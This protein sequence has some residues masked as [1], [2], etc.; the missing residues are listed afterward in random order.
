MAYP[1]GT[2]TLS[3]WGT[4][5]CTS[6][7]ASWKPWCR[8]VKLPSGDNSTFKAQ[9]NDPYQSPTANDCRRLAGHLHNVQSRTQSGLGRQAAK[10]LPLHRSAYRARQTTQSAAKTGTNTK[11]DRCPS[12]IK[13]LATHL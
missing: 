12:R 2:S 4:L 1:P 13:G 5:A 3:S 10:A 9:H 7:R 8:L 6:S 11:E